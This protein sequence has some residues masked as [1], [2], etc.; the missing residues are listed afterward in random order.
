MVKGYPDYYRGSILFGIK[1]GVP[2]GINMDDAGNLVAMLKAMFGTT[3]TTLACDEDGNLK[4]NIE[5]QTDIG[6]VEPAEAGTIFKTTEQNPLTEIKVKSAAGATN[7]PVDIAAISLGSL[8][9]KYNLGTFNY[10]TDSNSFAATG[11]N[12]LF[13][14]VGPFTIS[15]LDILFYGGD[16]IDD[17]VFTV[18]SGE[19][20]LQSFKGGDLVSDPSNLSGPSF[21]T[22]TCY[23]NTNHIYRFKLTDLLQVPSGNF[24]IH[25]AFNYSSTVYFVSSLVYFT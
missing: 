10:S 24:S 14:K 4:V 15:H 12:T 18:A 11:T 7:I 17:T 22:A 13:T 8:N 3:P 6:K 1:D 5:V 9:V 25:I 20:T 19:N 16:T 21:F 2:V 23:D